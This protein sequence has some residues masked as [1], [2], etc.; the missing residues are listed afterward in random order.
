MHTNHKEFR[1][2]YDRLF[3]LNAS[4]ARLRE[5][6][7]S[8]QFFPNAWHDAYDASTGMLPGRSILWKYELLFISPLTPTAAHP[9]LEQLRQSRQRYVDLLK[10]LLCAPDGSFE[11][12]V[13]I[14]GLQSN[15][16]VNDGATDNLARN[17]PLSLDLD[18]GWHDWFEAIELRK[19]IRKDVERT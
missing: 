5:A 17:N 3:N 13:E 6:V 8:G 18:S 2:I 9:P 10:Q 7:V 19:T 14:P 12:W 4:E 1:V 16:S 11:D 15:P